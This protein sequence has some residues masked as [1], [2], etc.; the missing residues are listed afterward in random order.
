VS[1]K[2]HVVKVAIVGEEYTIRSEAAPEHTRAVAEYL[3][4]AIR[5]VNSGGSSVVEAH[6][7]AILAALQIT[8][9]LFE[10]RR[11]ADEVTAVTRAL[12]ADVRRLL[13]PGKRGEGAA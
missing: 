5:S 12:S 9:E 7:A 2:K 8:A 4:R 1:G 11:A 6:K 10:A 3:D 13:P